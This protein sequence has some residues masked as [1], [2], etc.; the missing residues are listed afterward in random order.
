MKSKGGIFL[1]LFGAVFF[2]VGA[3]MGWFTVRS[4]Q[5]A[6]R[7]LGWSA[8]EAQILKCEL[9]RH[10]GNKGGVSYL[11][12]AQYEYQ[13][14]GV[15]YQNNRVGLSNTAD[16]IGSFQR[17]TYRRLEKSRREGSSVICWVNPEN[18]ADSILIR[19]PRVPLLLFKALFVLV[20]GAV[21]LGLSLSGML[22]AL[23]PNPA[24][25]GALQTRIRMR[26]VST[27][28]VAMAVAL[29][30]N[31]FTLWLSW[32]A[33]VVLTMAE[34]PLYFWGL[35]GSGVIP[36]LVAAYMFLRF[37][38]YGISV[39]EMSPLPGVLGGAVAGNIRIPKPIEAGDGFELTLQCIHQYTTRSG[40]NSTTHCDVLW[41][42]SQRVG[43]IYNY[44]TDMVLPVK[45]AA[46]Y[47]KPAT[48][49]AG[50]SNGYYWQLKVKAKKPGIDY[51]AVFDVPVKHTAQSVEHTQE[52]HSFSGAAQDAAMPALEEVISDMG[53]SY[54]RSAEGVI[55]LGFP[56]LRAKGAAT[57]V[58]F[59][60]IIWSGACWLIVRSRAPLLFAGVF[61]FF[62]LLLVFMLLQLMF[63]ASMVRFDPYQRKLIL[64]KY[65]AGIPYKRREFDL[66][67]LGGFEFE[68]GMQ[69]GSTCYYRILV[70]LVSGK[71]VK[72]GDM[73]ESRSGAQRLTKELTQWEHF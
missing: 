66:S 24:D 6:E 21:G 28:K 55:E 67:E 2:A 16:N 44:G 15:A 4:M 36:A 58:L 61:I 39:F 22:A 48:N 53:L 25:G 10:S 11:V 40:K 43:T 32:K 26:G 56:A 70:R 63:A 9:K 13:I 17:D 29:Y 34:I 51:N 52:Q 3:G 49:T 38:K 18:V 27:H 20:F 8:C 59:F 23:T 45:F 1:A 35:A 5:Q 7:M 57:G 41:E 33:V 60:I 69:S 31:V 14:N 37:N 50:K 12:Q 72:L 46:P 68:R 65:W 47:D 71:S 54:T 64:F 73:L 19:K 42:E 62:D 30:W